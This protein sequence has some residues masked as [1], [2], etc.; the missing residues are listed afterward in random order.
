MPIN[1]KRVRRQDDNSLASLGICFGDI[2]PKVR[3][4]YPNQKIIIIIQS[5]RAPFILLS[6]KNGGKFLKNN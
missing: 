2:L 4:K 1:L 3:E 6:A 5:S